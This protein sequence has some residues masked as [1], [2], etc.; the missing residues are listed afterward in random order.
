M[1]AQDDHWQENF[2]KGTQLREQGRVA[3]ADKALLTA[4]KEAEKFGDVS[5][6]L[7]VHGADF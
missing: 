2:P 1:L 7:A 4:R 3:K 6:V 5:G